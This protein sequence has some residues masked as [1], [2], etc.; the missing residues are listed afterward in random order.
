MSRRMFVSCNPLPKRM[1]LRFHEDGV[2]VSQRR[3]VGHRDSGPKLANTSRDKVGV[4]IEVGPPFQRFYLPFVFP[5]K[6]CQ[7]ELHPLSQRQ[8]QVVNVLLIA[9][10]QCFEEVK[11]LR[12]A[13]EQF[14]F[15]MSFA[16]V[17][18]GS[19]AECRSR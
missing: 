2:P 15:G 4:L 19:F 1:A 14:S 6:H 16:V 18:R 8:H 3:H 7:I 5:G 13:G 17:R 10:R 9:G 11:A 12:Q